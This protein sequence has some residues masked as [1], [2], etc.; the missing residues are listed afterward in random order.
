MRVIFCKVAL[1]LFSFGKSATVHQT[2]FVL[3]D[4]L[5]IMAENDFVAAG[6][7]LNVQ[8]QLREVLS[9]LRDQREQVQSPKEELQGSALSVASE[10]KKLKKDVVWKYQAN[11]I[12]F[13]FNNQVDEVVKQAL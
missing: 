5:C 4:C 10:V 2:F 6:D 12:Q 11:K 8:D 7:N 1:S 13:D 3:L 9:E